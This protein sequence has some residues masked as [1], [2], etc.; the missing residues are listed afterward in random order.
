MRED[1]V[2]TLKAM[3]MSRTQAKGLFAGA[4]T[5]MEELNLRI[6]ESKASFDKTM[7]HVEKQWEIATAQ[8][9]RVQEIGACG[10]EAG[11][12]FAREKEIEGLKEAYKKLGG[13]L[14]DLNL[15]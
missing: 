9:N 4:K 10:V 7:Q 5:A 3:R 13:E 11:G 12:A 6:A 14:N 8:G 2:S 15:K 1:Y